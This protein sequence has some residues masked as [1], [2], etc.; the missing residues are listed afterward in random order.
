[1][2]SDSGDRHFM[3]KTTAF[4]MPVDPLVALQP[5]PAQ[6]GEDAWH[7]PQNNPKKP[8]KLALKSVCG[9]VV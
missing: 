8:A 9:I 4:G 5:K 3:L 7:V 1:M 6:T 2:A